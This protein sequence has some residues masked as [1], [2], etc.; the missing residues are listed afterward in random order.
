[1]YIQ[2]ISKILEH[3]VCN[4]FNLWLYKT[5]PTIKQ[6]RRTVMPKA[7]PGSSSRKGPNPRAKPKPAPKAAQSQPEATPKKNPA[8]KPA[9]KPAAKRARR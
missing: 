7:A 2:H 4:P 1:M 5:P 3:V 8:P 9:V 6:P